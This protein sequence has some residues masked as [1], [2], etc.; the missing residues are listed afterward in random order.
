MSGNL[1]LVLV[2]FNARQENFKVLR[3][4]EFIVDQGRQTPG[5]SL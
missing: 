5:E 3:T 4:Y 1:A 2:Y